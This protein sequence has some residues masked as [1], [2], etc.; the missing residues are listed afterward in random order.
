M[1]Q[2][3]PRAS[4]LPDLFGSERLRSARKLPGAAHFQETRMRTKKGFGPVARPAGSRK[5]VPST[6]CEPGAGVEVHLDPWE[7]PGDE[8]C[9]LSQG[10]SRF[11]SVKL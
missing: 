2:S 5:E 4:A 11:V 7:Q 9:G 3:G 6:S 8:E 10:G 1:L